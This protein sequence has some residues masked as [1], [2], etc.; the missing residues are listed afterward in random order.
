M[1]FNKASPRPKDCLSASQYQLTL[2]G[3]DCIQLYQSRGQNFSLSGE[4]ENFN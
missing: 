2:S 1:F 4:H 3:R